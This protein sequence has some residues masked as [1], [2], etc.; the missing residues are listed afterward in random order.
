[1][2]YVIRNEDVEEI[3]IG[4]PKN[5]KHLRI[6]IKIGDKTLIFQEATIA[7]LVRAYTAVKTHPTIK[8]L[9]LKRKTL[10]ERE[11]KTGY[12]RH[13]LIEVEEKEE[14]I[15]REITK[16]LEEAQLF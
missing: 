2:T 1:M 11:I 13:Q 12:A 5:H 6:Y 3:L 4:I 8:A 7:N 9:K 10:P 14:E 15:E 16:L